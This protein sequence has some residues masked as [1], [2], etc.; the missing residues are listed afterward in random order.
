M[1]ILT[2][3]KLK[4]GKG[5]PMESVL[6]MEPEA[7]SRLSLLDSEVREAIRRNPSEGLCCKKFD[8]NLTGSLQGIPLTEGTVLRAGGAVLKIVSGKK[9]FPECSLVRE[10]KTC[11]LRKGACFAEIQKSGIIRVGEEITAD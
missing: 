1:G 7:G 11:P 5:I 3:L 10:K 8:A 2:E 9:C 4:K 6:E